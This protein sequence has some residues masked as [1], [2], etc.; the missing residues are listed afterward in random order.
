MSKHVLAVILFLGIAGSAGAESLRD[1]FWPIGYYPDGRGGE[2]I[3]ESPL[4]FDDLSPEE[5]ALI[6]RHMNVSGILKQSGSYFAFI[7]GLVVKAGDII[8]LAVGTKS[9]RFRI[10]EISDNTI[11]LEPLRDKTEKVN[12]NPTP[13]GIE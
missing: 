12:A 4:N 7:N 11:N 9:Y 10:R 2:V 5:Q 13:G 3:D 6:R 8:P 1:P